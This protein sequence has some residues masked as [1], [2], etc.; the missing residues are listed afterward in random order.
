MN[1]TREEIAAKIK[2]FKRWYHNI[3]LHGVLTNPANPSYPEVRWRLIERYVPEDLTG[4]TVLDVGCNAGY[5]SIKM[6]QRGA[7]VV[8]VD[9]YTD[10]IEQARFVADVL[11]LD[12]E[13]RCQN[14]RLR[15][16][17]RCVLSP[18]LP[19]VNLGSPVGCLKTP[20]SEHFWCT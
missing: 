5:F 11:A 19:V 17:S 1:Y 10:G 6:K 7:R 14:I 8:G 15:P 4:K 20:S 3:D 12:I 13:Y 16:L 9:W 18:T 2:R